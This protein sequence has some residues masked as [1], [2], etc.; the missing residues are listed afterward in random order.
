MCDLLSADAPAKHPGHFRLQAA[1]GKNRISVASCPF[2]SKRPNM[3]LRSVSVR[4]A[5]GVFGTV[6]LSILELIS[7]LGVIDKRD[8]LT[9][10]SS[11]R[12]WPQVMGEVSIAQTISQRR[13]IVRV[14]AMSRHTQTFI[15]VDAILSPRSELGS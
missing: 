7:S 5:G 1:Q 14:L 15:W 9:N 4:S 11:R 6:C 8:Y 3:F 10:I 2:L 12:P 13:S